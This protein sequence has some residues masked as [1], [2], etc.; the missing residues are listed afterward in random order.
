MFL[1]EIYLALCSREKSVNLEHIHSVLN[2]VKGMADLETK[3]KDLEDALSCSQSYLSAKEKAEALDRVHTEVPSCLTENWNK[4]DFVRF[5]STYSPLVGIN[6][7]ETIV[8][9]VKAMRAP[10]IFGLFKIFG[11]KDASGEKV[12]LFLPALSLT[13]KLL[14]EPAKVKD[15]CHADYN[16][17][18]FAQYFCESTWHKVKDDSNSDPLPILSMNERRL[19]EQEVMYDCFLKIN[20]LLEAINT[21]FFCL[22]IVYNKISAVMRYLA[23]IEIFALK[24][25]INNKTSIKA[26]SMKSGMYQLMP[27][28]HRSLLDEKEKSAAEAKVEE[29]DNIL[30]TVS[31]NIKNLIYS[32]T[33]NLSDGVKEAPDNI[34]NSLQMALSGARAIQNMVRNIQMAYK[35]TFEQFLYDIN[36]NNHQEAYV[37]DDVISEVLDVVVENMFTDEFKNERQHFFENDVKM[38]NLKKVFYDLPQNKSEILDF[39][40]TNLTRIKI[41]I[42]DQLLQSKIGNTYGSLTNIYVLLNE[43]MMNSFKAL[44]FVAPEKRFFVLEGR[45]TENELIFIMQNSCCA[46]SKDLLKAEGFGTFIANRIIESIGKVER[47]C[48]EE[49]FTLKLVIPVRKDQI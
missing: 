31:H 13:C 23:E 40:R 26:F 43:F 39:V 3:I 6:A 48:S 30:K 7:C 41:D 2:E 24:L 10:G 28:S 21:R 25:L 18:S 42:D 38:Q 37:L 32:V 35:Y 9:F 49:L 20:M 46:E 22:P 4:E 14:F 19:D 5:T 45:V 11:R 8:S 15:K 29:R 1:N 33:E 44:A 27:E 34:R 47:K 36:D 16:A 17:G 12:P